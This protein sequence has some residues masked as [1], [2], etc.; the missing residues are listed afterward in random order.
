MNFVLERGELKQQI[1][2]RR[3]LFVFQAS[4][5]GSLP[6]D[7]PMINLEIQP[8]PDH[9]LLSTGIRFHRQCSNCFARSQGKAVVGTNV[10]LRRRGKGYCGR[11]DDRDGN[12][13]SHGVSAPK[14]P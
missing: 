11:R 1:Y 13:D 12:G 9:K 10:S 5:N 6:I 8:Q 2:E 14:L 4:A 7:N 3:S